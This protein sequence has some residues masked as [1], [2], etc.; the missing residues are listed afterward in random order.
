MLRDDSR[1]LRASAILLIMAV[2]PGQWFFV[3]RHPL[4]PQIT[5]FY[6]DEFCGRC[7][8]NGV[9]RFLV[10]LYLHNFFIVS[11]KREEEIK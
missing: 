4:Q 9:R 3:V 5:A 1:Q 7:C 11:I 8:F 6:K 10:L 2:I